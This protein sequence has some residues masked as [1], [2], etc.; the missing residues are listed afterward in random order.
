MNAVFWSFR[1]TSDLPPSTVALELKLAIPIIW[2]IFFSIYVVF[3]D[4]MARTLTSDRCTPYCK[5]PSM[6]HNSFKY[7][8]PIVIQTPWPSLHND[9]STANK[10]YSIASWLIKQ[11]DL[12]VKYDPKISIES[13][14]TQMASESLVTN[15][16]QGYLNHLQGKLSECTMASR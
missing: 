4:F 13:V 2:S 1:H 8:K 15:A 16:S 7:R 11:D 14:T 12:S 10:Y 3:A 6:S 5:V 9:G